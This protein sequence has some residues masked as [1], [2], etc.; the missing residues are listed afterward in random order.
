M[1]IKNIIL[2]KNL[3]KILIINF[4]YLN[5]YEINSLLKIIVI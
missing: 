2:N 5:I 4:F 1:I 3:V